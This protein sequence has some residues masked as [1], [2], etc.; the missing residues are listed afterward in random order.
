VAEPR[1][2][3]TGD[4][5]AAAATGREGRSDG[6]A[7]P[8]SRVPADIRNV[9]FPASMRGYDRA[10]VDAYVRRA[11]RVIAELEV[12]QSPQAAVRHAVERVSEQ[13]KTILEEAR[14]SA[15]K[16]TAT[17]RAEA[18]EI[19]AAAKAEAAELV[20]N[21]GDEADRVRAEAEQLIAN[22]RAEAE[23]ILGTANAQAAERRRVSEEELASLQA[24]AEAKMRELETDTDAVRLERQALLDDIEG[25]A[26]RLHDAASQAAARFSNETPAEE[27]WPTDGEETTVPPP[28]SAAETL[29][30]AAPAPR[31]GASSGRKKA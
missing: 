11:N 1:A 18:D 5:N 23:R 9:S 26:T 3:N 8:K 15:E 14:E 22:A 19:L 2:A 16:I 10:A 29:V 28:D 6:A 4:E 20:V 31:K 13:T 24:E 17:A 21:A 30:D 7:Q 12:T 27:G 25:M